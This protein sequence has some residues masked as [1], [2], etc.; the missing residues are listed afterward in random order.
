MKLHSVMR[1]SFVVA[2]AGLF[3]ISP[4]GL[5]QLGLWVFLGS[6]L[7]VVIWFLGWFLEDF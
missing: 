2:V 5:V 1:L 7:L 4:L 6:P 3:M